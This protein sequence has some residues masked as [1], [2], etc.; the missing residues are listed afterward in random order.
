MSGASAILGAQP[1]ATH[2]DAL[3]AELERQLAGTTN[4]EV[5]ASLQ[6][7]LWMERQSQEQERV[8]RSAPVDPTRL[9][10][11]AAILEATSA[12]LDAL[13]TVIITLPRE[14]AG[15][16]YIVEGAQPP[17]PSMQFA[18]RNQWFTEDG[19]GTR[20]IVWAG[21]QGTPEGQRKDNQGAIM[22]DVQ[23]ASTGGPGRFQG[24]FPT[25]PMHGAVRVSGATGNVIIL[26]ADDGTTWQF[27]VDLRAYR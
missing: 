13:P 2:S 22:I 18:G 8:A 19:A 26:E 25:P 3:V 11:K 9:A 1:P 17:F 20:V 24:F 4:P 6:E 12:A 27:D 21:E 14:P 7:K 10:A 5:V 23:D 16:G 15:G